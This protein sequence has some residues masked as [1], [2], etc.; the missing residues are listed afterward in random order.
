MP[1][2][3]QGDFPVPP[4]PDVS[5]EAPLSEAVKVPGI[6]ITVS[7]KLPDETHIMMRTAVFADEPKESVDS[8]LD[9]L[10]SHMERQAAKVSLDAVEEQLHRDV[11][12][13]GTMIAALPTAEKVFLEKLEVVK[14]ELQEQGKEANDVRQK[15]EED[16]RKSGR[17]GEL[18]L[19]G[20]A[21]LNM[22]RIAKSNKDSLAKVE[23]IHAER[24]AEASQT[25]QNIAHARE[26]VNT[27]LEKVNDLRRVS[28]REPL[29]D[30]NIQ[31]WL[32]CPL[33]EIGD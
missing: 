2:S 24:L 8:L 17:G 30:A 18:E 12:S 1:G 14:A 3:Y 4:V 6:D 25:L 5:K 11:M 16:W 7:R 31:N 23:K 22:K 29:V 19:V 15:A 28:G 26:T 21:A 13:L 33:P 27:L 9:R 32:T 20:R 10:S